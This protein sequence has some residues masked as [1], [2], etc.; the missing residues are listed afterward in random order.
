MSQAVSLFGTFTC[1]GVLAGDQPPGIRSLDL[2]PEPS[3]VGP[4]GP[5]VGEQPPEFLTRLSLSVW[6]ACL[7]EAQ[8]SGLKMLPE[9]P[10]LPLMPLPARLFQAKRIQSPGWAPGSEPERTCGSRRPRSRAVG[11]LVQGIE[12]HAR[13]SGPQRQVLPPNTAWT[14]FPEITQRPVFLM[15]LHQPAVPTGNTASGH[16]ARVQELSSQR[17]VLRA[18]TAPCQGHVG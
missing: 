4:R 10:G 3:I 7:Q 16:P 15:L 18:P 11:V 1:E 6:L 8:V 5:G 2:L 9:C 12:G 17:L 13:S 14:V